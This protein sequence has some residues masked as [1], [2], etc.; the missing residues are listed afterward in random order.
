MIQHGVNFNNYNSYRDFGLILMSVSNPNPEPKYEFIQVPFS[1]DVIDL[2]EV[3]GDV[4]YKQ[5]KLI[6]KFLCLDKFEERF[7]NKG[8][9]SELL[10]GQKLKII[11]D[12]DPLHYYVGRVS[13]T[14]WDVKKK[15]QIVTIEC[16]CEPYRYDIE[17]TGAPWK[18]DPFSFVEG[19]IRDS[20]N[21][22]VDGEIE[23]YIIGTNK[24][25]YPTVKCSADM[26][27]S[28]NDGEFVKFSAGSTKAYDLPIPRGEK[29]NKVVVRGNGN[30][31][32]TFRG[33][34][35]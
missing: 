1:S 3:S 30:I 6:F 24:I 4:N 7:A 27:V 5:R 25:I 8:T 2:T 21:W 29:R 9:I 35:F 19:I 33:V 17:E 23:K 15:A 18:W 26:E 32:I 31:S 22:I 16:I 11:I 34:S 28:I 20:G 13:L 14:T 10:H 12:D